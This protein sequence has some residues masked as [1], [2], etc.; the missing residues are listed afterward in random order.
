LSIPILKPA[1][2]ATSNDKY[3][4]PPV[5]PDVLINDIAWDVEV[6][7]ELCKTDKPFDVAVGAYDFVIYS[8]F[9]AAELLSPMFNLDIIL[10]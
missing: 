1:T 10:T 2:P 3:G 8:P 7:P 5:A 4:F 6:T 9:V